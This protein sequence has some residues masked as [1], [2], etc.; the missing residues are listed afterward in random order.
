MNARQ[1]RLLPFLAA[2]LLFG[3]AMDIVS[4]KQAP[5]TFTPAGDPG[6]PVVLQ[7]DIAVSIGTGFATKLKQGTTWRAVGKIAEGE[8][9]STRDQIVTVEAS[10][11][12]EAQPVISS[13]QIVGF[14][15]PVERTFTP[16]TASVAA[17]FQ[18]AK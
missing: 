13:G 10:N 7:R 4:V 8:A 15:L 12:H 2:L 6:A 17:T 3:C 14:Y 1:I 9:F 18:P 5:A 16:A 11:I